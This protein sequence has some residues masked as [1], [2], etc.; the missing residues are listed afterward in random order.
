M[1]ELDFI[2]LTTLLPFFIV[3]FR[4]KIKTNDLFGKHDPPWSWRKMKIDEGR[5]RA[6]AA[7]PN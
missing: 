3:Y 5:E 7:G 2:L 4:S 1:T 6:I